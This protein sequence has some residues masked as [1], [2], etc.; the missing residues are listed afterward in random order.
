MRHLPMLPPGVEAVVDDETRKMRERE[1]GR[2]D[3]GAISHRPRKHL[4]GGL[5]RRLL[6]ERDFVPLHE[7]A[8][9]GV[10]L[11]VDVDLDRAD[12]AA[13]AIERRG[14]RQVAVLVCVEG[15]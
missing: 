8:P 12:V 11:L 1:I 3:R 4:A 5:H 15:R 6:Y 7:L 9:P 13:A 10:D 14:K 2:G